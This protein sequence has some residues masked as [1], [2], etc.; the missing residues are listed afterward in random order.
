MSKHVA[1][2]CFFH[3]RSMRSWGVP[4]TKGAHMQIRL[5][6]A[7]LCLVIIGALPSTWF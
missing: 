5:L 4:L 2:A 6:F 3:R 1:L 7:T